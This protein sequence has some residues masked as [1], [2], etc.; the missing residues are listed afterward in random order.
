MILVEYETPELLQD[1]S[2]YLTGIISEA[3]EFLPLKTSLFFEEK[4]QSKLWNLYA[5]PYDCVLERQ[6]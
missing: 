2:N 1:V 5:G 4:M 3:I 6:D